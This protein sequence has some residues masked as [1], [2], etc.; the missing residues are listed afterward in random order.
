MAQSSQSLNIQRTLVRTRRMDSLPTTQ[1][2]WKQ[3]GYIDIINLR[4]NRQYHKKSL[5][6]NNEKKTTLL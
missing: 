1:T 6:F 4:K 3:M 5:E 2:L